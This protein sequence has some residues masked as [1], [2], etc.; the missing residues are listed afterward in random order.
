MF[1]KVLS[2]GNY[3]YYQKYYHTDKGKWLQV[4]VTKPSKS[5][6]VQAQAQKYLDEKIDRI[7]NQQ[8]KADYCIKDV[9][10]D[11]LYIRSQEL[12]ESTYSVQKVFLLNFVQ[13]FG[14]YKLVQVQSIQIQRYILDK[15][16]S[17][18]Y[19]VHVK[20]ILH[21]FFEYCKK[22]GYIIKNP[23]TGVV[24]PKNKLSIEKVKQL[25]ER[26]LTRSEFKEFLEYVQTNSGNKIFILFSEFMYLTGLRYGEAAA[27]DWKNVDLE[28]QFLVVECTLHFRKNGNYYLTS[29]KTVNA[30]RKVFFNKRVVE[31]LREIRDY[32]GHQGGLVFLYKNKPIRNVSFNSFL[33]KNFTRCP[34]SKDNDFI[35]TSHVLRHSYISLLAELSIPIKVVMEQVGHGDE[36]TTLSIY[37]H[38]TENM[39]V[40]LQ[41]KLELLD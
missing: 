6:A 10:D 2:N 19:M 36:K 18:G 7:L 21:L 37:T 14:N 30:Y 23:V 5:R 38:V 29:P 24:L 4:S 31:L 33:K 20:A 26:Y 17:K 40:D 15:K 41:L 25:R 22:L 3:R 8:L 12:K 28:N 39:K 1:Y 34:V 11:W 32:I 27:L 9:I 13:K 16:W 35:L